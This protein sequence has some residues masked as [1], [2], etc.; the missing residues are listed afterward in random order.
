MLSA[1]DLLMRRKSRSAIR[2][3]LSTFGNPYSKNLFPDILSGCIV[4]KSDGGLEVNN[5]VSDGM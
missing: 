5:I 1:D 2:Y 3:M 4:K